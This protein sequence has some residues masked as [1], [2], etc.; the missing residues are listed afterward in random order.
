MNCTLLAAAVLPS[1]SSLVLMDS[2][3]KGTALLLLAAI[4]ALILRRDSAAT[5]Y[6]VWMLAIIAMLVVPALS[7]MLPQ[8]RVLP[9]W[10]EVRLETAVAGTS[11]FSIARGRHALTPMIG[12]LQPWP[13]N[14]AK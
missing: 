5:R 13:K 8:W 7:S 12:Q 3:V 11:P 14:R 9:R 1:D 4:A 10:T 6:L 2:A